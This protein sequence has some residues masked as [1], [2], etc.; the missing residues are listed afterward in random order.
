VGAGGA[1]SAVLTGEHAAAGG[2]VLRFGAVSVA[3][4]ARGRAKEFWLNDFNQPLAEL[5]ALTIKSRKR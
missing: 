1:D 2:A 4:A 3:A 5:L